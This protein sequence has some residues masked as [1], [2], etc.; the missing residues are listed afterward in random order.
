MPD[1]G[2]HVTAHSSGPQLSRWCLHTHPPPCLPPAPAAT[3]SRLLHP[4]S[5]QPDTAT[6]APE[7]TILKEVIKLYNANSP[8]NY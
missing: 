5:A 2:E 1:A 3:S 6:A 4:H 7:H 8:N